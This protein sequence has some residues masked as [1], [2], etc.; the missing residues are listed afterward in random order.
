MHGLKRIINCFGISPFFLGGEGYF[1]KPSN[2]HEFNVETD[3][4]I[5]SLKTNDT[6]ITYGIEEV[7]SYPNVCFKIWSIAFLWGLTNQ[8]LFSFRP[9]P[10][11][12]NVVQAESCSNLLKEAKFCKDPVG[13]EP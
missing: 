2:D 6:L 13:F 10:N 11:L 9:C 7:V 3:I 1:K 12:R 5:C 8:A 4:N